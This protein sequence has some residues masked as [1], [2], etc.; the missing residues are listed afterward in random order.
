MESTDYYSPTP[1]GNPDG[2]GVV[3]VLQDWGALA[4]GGVRPKAPAQVLVDYWSSLLVLSAR[5]DFKVLPGRWYHLYRVRDN[6]QLSLISPSEWGARLPGPYLC[7][8]QL[9]SD[10][11][12]EL[13]FDDLALEDTALRE[14]LAAFFGGF[15]DSL[16]SAEALEDSLPLY[17]SNLPYRQRMLATALSS[18]LTHSLK[19][20]GL[21]NVRSHVW[22]EQLAAEAA[23]PGLTLR[24]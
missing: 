17:Q 20:S 22:L 24:P 8:C 11:T 23:V 12:W 19:L 3:P 14:A 9:R 16:S 15:T 5:F 2:K 21:D 10:M 4:P 6:W 18:S 13:R 1:E 7:D